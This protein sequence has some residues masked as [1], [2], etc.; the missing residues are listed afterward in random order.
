MFWKSTV[1]DCRLA[2]DYDHYLH[3]VVSAYLAR[4]DLAITDDDVLWAM[5]THGY[6]GVWEQFNRPLGWCLR[7]ADMLEPSRDWSINRWVKDTVGLVREAAYTGHLTEAAILWTE[8]LIV[9]F[10]GDGIAVHPNMQRVCASDSF[11][12]Y[13]FCA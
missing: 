10:E 8:R 4:R 9:W 1:H 5:T 6:Y 13:E 12:V 2:Y 3:G 7:M 11:N